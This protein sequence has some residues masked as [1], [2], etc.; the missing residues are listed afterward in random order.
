MPEQFSF[1]EPL[2]LSQSL[3]V[4]PESIQEGRSRN[5]KLTMQGLGSCS[6][7][8]DLERA[9]TSGAPE[10]ECWWHILMCTYASREFPALAAL[11]GITPRIPAC[12]ARSCG[13]NIYIYI[14]IHIYI[15]VWYSSSFF[16]DYPYINPN[17]TP[18]GFW[19][20]T[21]ILARTEAEGSKSKKRAAATPAGPD[22]QLSGLD[23][24]NCYALRVWYIG[25]IWGWY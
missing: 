24:S 21:L 4:I 25:V 23:L 19:K 13:S 6:K 8:A 16:F 15:L 22:G 9:L 7:R 3:L 11:V 12:G 20:S 14:C 5:A 1:C 18:M 2:S 17:I 10:A